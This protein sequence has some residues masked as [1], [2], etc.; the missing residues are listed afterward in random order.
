MPVVAGIDDS[1]VTSLVIE[2]A[3]EQARWRGT[4]LK[5][6]HVL[7]LPTVHAGALVD[8][9]KVA[10]AQR[11]AVWAA[12]DAHLAD[13]GFTVERVDLDGYPPDALVEYATEV[14]ASLL[15]VGTRARG[16][17]AS[18]ILGST[19]HRATYLASCDVLVVKG[20]EREG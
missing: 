5:L 20:G 11:D 9:R 7:H 3:L 19:S 8:W 18:L 6:V 4:E 2:R 1:P 15:V 10:A 17:L 14:D 16:E 13:A 12:A